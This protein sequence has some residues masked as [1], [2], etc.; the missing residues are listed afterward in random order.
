MPHHIFMYGQQSLMYTDKVY[1]D[2]KY[3]RLIVR[4]DKKI[5]SNYFGWKL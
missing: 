4:A 2:P 3:H 5:Y 1:K